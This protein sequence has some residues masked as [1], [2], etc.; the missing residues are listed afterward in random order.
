M[1]WMCIS[2]PLLFLTTCEMLIEFLSRPVS[3]LYTL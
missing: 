2:D 3:N 1:I